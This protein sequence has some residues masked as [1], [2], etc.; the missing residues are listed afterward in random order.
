VPVNG[1]PGATRSRHD[2]IYRLETATV[3]SLL[4]HRSMLI[5]TNRAALQRTIGE[6][7]GQF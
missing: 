2:I 4:A 7:D 1:S 5:S 6:T 3:T